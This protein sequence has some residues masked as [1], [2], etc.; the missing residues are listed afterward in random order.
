MSAVPMT[1]AACRHCRTPFEPAHPDDAFCCEGC[2]FVHHLLGERGLEEFYRYGGPIAPAHPDVFH[3][4]DQ[5]WLRQAQKERE[6]GGG[7]ACELEVEVQGI[8]CAGCVWLLE[9]LFQDSE[10]SLSCQADSV[11]GTLRMRWL[12]GQCDLAAYAAEVRKFGYFLGPLTSAPRRGNRAL[13]LRLGICGALA[14]NAMLF[15]LPHYLGIEV[16]SGLA[17]LFGIIAFVLASLSFLIGGGYFFTRAL[18]VL[19]SGA[20]NI[21]VPIALGLVFAYAGSVVAWRT[22]HPGFVYFD[23]ISIFSFLMLTGR[24]LQE[25]ALEANRARLL[26]LRVSPGSFPTREGETVPAEKLTRGV[27]YAV[28]RRQ[29]IPVR[30]RLMEGEAMI[31]LS[32]ITGEPH[33]RRV[34]RGGCIP[35]GA[36][37]LSP[38]PLAVEALEDWPDAQLSRLLRIEGGNPWRNENLQRVM[39]IYLASVIGLAA[40]GFLAWGCFSGDWVRAMQVLVSVLVV[41]CPCSIGIALPLVDDLSAALLQHRGIY[42]KDGTL[43]DRLLRVR[44]ILFDKTGTV[45][46]ETLGLADPEA[47]RRLPKAVK[48]ALLR[49]QSESLHPVAACLREVLLAEG[50]EPAEGGEE[51][52]EIIGFGVEW[53]DGKSVWKVG[54][55]GW[56]VPG[57]APQADGTVLSR[58]GVLVA[59]M[60]FREQLRPQAIQQVRQLQKMGYG[61]HL[62]SGDDAGRVSAM[63][64]KIG[65]EE[66]GAFG[67]LTPE[68]KAALIRRHW[69]ADALM[70]GDGANDSLAFD[71][72]LC[73]GTPAVNSGLLEQKSDFYILGRSLGGI[74]G[75]FETARRHQAV[76]R[77]VFAFAVAYNAAAMA[78]S[79]GGIMSPLVAA[80]IMPLSSL[81]SLGIVMLGFRIPTSSP[82]PKPEP[83]PSAY[84]TA[85]T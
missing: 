73:R 74:A 54:R 53:H 32:W 68:D 49:L 19:R 38:A 84:A 78:F 35:S 48:S 7:D 4:A 70:I 47:L 8:S 23:F 28:G 77:N 46:L 37:N 18:A 24:W 39:R 60:A 50:I 33:P 67:G 75:L 31:G 51:P 71:A 80:I 61:V 27:A 11:N 69:V 34:P 13:V 72:A 26:R 30:S 3:G 83:T 9:Q 81:I 17:R 55:P 63:A 45:T 76:S 62:L 65:L 44:H 20:L 2:R 16:Q 59:E 57:R 14:M 36:T 21:D 58:D 66:S 82:E 56:A 10:G 40:G 5:E 43:W 12:S 29:L 64:G 6:A 15:S 85:T 42:V 1:T 25:R 79:L 52:R 41:S 22:G